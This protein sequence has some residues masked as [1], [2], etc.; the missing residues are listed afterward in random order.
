MTDDRPKKSWRELDR[1]RDRR[2]G[3]PRRP[4]E[5]ERNR[6]RASTSAAYSQYKSKLDGLFKPGGTELPEHMR[7][8][9]GPQS[10]EGK[11]HKE[12]TDALMKTP[13]KETLQAFVDAGFVLPENPR[14]LTQLLD[15]R[16]EALTRSVLSRLVELI[17]QGK[18]PN[19]M[20]LLQRMTAAENWVEEDETRSL[21]EALK[22]RL[23]G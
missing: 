3:S 18:K 16:D 19:R 6:E 9:L 21:M 8:S 12:L 7:A 14:L 11:L 10:D 2:S 4:D 23:E 13:S 17:E 22:E 1:N 20:L 5:A 15:T